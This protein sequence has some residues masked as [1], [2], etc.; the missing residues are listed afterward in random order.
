MQRIVV[1]EGLET[2]A[3]LFLSLR[4]KFLLCSAMLECDRDAY[5]ILQR[6]LKANISVSAPDPLAAL[7]EAKRKRA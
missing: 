2:N 1:I 3:Q 6:M 7:A 5:K 4:A